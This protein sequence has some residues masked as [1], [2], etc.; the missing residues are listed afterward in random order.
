MDAAFQCIDA[1][2]PEI[3]DLSDETRTVK[4]YEDMTSR[5]TITYSSSTGLSGLSTDVDISDVWG[6]HPVE[7]CF[8]EN[9]TRITFCSV[10]QLL[11]IGAELVN[12]CK[13][14][15]QDELDELQM[16]TTTSQ[17]MRQIAG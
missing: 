13:E 8:S 3:W 11:L 12:E 7:I 15:Y 9:R 1:P 10:G 14:Y 6:T 4:V 17:Q 16:Y 5:E 2:F